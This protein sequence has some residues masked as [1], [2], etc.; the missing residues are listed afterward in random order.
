MVAGLIGLILV[1]GLGFFWPADV[2]RLTLRDGKVVTGQI[3]EREAIPGKPGEH[4]IKLKVGNRDLYGA[5][6]VWIDESQVA[7]RATPPEVA[8]IERTEWGALIGTIREVREG[9]RVVRPARSPTRARWRASWRR[10]RGCV[11]EIRSIEKG[12][13]GAI[14]HRQE[15]IRLRLRDARARWRARRPAGAGAAARSWRGSTPGTRRRRR[16][17]AS[18]ARGRRPASW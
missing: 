13:I 16:G 18:S 8:V 11:G 10:P 12:D 14:N 2:T 4:R 7:G 6:F 17:S 3:V 9:G 1:N 5:D 15:R